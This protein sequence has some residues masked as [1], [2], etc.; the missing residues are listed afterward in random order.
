MEHS[1]RAVG[2]PRYLDLA[3]IEEQAKDVIGE[4]AYA[5]YSGGAGEETLLADNVA[6]WRHFELHPRVL[7]DVSSID[8]RTR[9]LG[10]EVASPLMVAPT[11]IQGMAHATA[12]CATARAAKRAG[13]ALTLSSLA[14]CS[15]EEVA[16][17]APGGVHFMQV[18]VLRDRGKTAEMI[19]RALAAGYRALVL[20]VDAPVSGQRIR[21]I[22]GKVHLPQGL[23]LPNMPAASVAKAKEGGFMSV[24]SE[25]IDPSLD[26]RVIDWLS[27]ISGLPIVIKGIARPDD[28]R[29]LID[30]GAAAVIVSNHGARQL[31]DAPP[32]ARLLAPIA[33]AI[34][35]R[36]EVWVDGGIRRPADVVKALSLGA[37]AAMIGR[38]YLW[39]LAAGGEDGVFELLEYFSEEIRRTMALCGTPTID[40]IDGSIVAPK[41]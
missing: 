19:A 40:S 4:M 20:T 14:T 38:P 1:P 41:A 33:E 29:C 13:V 7:V 28:A 17:A 11:A 15:L 12:E 37:R 24:V 8:T 32:T 21:E 16:E 9:I 22:T 10:H 3:A 5:Y 27:S 34:G 25:E 35:D 36:G 30:S 2:R 23:T 26:Y 31:D 6:A 39:S 18:Y